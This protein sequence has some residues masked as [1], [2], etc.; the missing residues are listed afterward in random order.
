MRWEPTFILGAW[1]VAA[2][3]GSKPAVEDATTRGASEPDHERTEPFRGDHAHRAAAAVVRVGGTLMAGATSLR[4]PE[5]AG[6][7][8]VTVAVRGERDGKVEVETLGSTRGCTGHFPGVDAFRLRFTVERHDLLMVV[9]EPIRHDFSDGTSIELAPGVPLKARLPGACKAVA[10]T[11]EVVLPIP[12][13]KLGTYFTRA[14]PFGMEEGLRVIYGE[15][16][17]HYGPD[18]TLASAGLYGGPH[19]ALATAGLYGGPHETLVFESHD[20]GEHARVTVRNA[21][22]QAV[23][24]TESARV[25]PLGTRILGMMHKTGGYWSGPSRA[26]QVDRADQAAYLKHVGAPALAE[27][28]AIY[29]ED[30]TLAGEVAAQLW[31]DGDGVEIDGRRCRDYPLVDGGP[32]ALT[33]CYDP[34]SVIIARGFDYESK[35][36]PAGHGP[37][38]RVRLKTLV[39]DGPLPEEDLRPFILFGSIDQLR[40]CRWAVDAGERRP[41]GRVEIAFTIDEEGDVIEAEVVE[42]TL[43]S[44]RFGE[45][46]AET[47]EGWEFPGSPAGIVDVRA[48]YLVSP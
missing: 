9:T 22:L 8:G 20:D 43:D 44:E 16:K 41:K 3:T 38:P 7:L 25:M 19:E 42:T 17:L 12:V 34:A 30:G 47:M 26:E 24:R 39:V 6:A 1:M 48:T 15:P 37:P 18:Q 36:R 33:L 29:W 10:R 27:G 2:C 21:C 14:E 32:A 5:L 35:R 28:T 46:M 13:T 40:G 11:T 45:C 23:V 31:V 4:V